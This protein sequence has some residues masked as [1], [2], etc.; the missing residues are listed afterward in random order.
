MTIPLEE[1]VSYPERQFMEETRGLSDPS[2]RFYDINRLVLCRLTQTSNQLLIPWLLMS[3]VGYEIGLPILDDATFDEIAQ[4]IWV[5]RH[6]PDLQGHRHFAVAMSM[7]TDLGKATNSAL[8]WRKIPQ[9]VFGAAAMR[10]YITDLLSR[11][12]VPNSL[13][14]QAQPMSEISHKFL[15]F[16]TSLHTTQQMELPL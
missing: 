14:L 12:V 2:A 7:F 16:Y 9:I 4:T 8:A 3:A 1:I 5:N 10:Y 13:V 11:D 6:D 15:H